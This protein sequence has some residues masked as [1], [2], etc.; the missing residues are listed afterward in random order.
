MNP[1]SKTVST[2]QQ[3]R[4]CRCVHFTGIQHATCSV[5]VKY[6]SFTRDKS[7]PCLLKAPLHTEQHVCDKY[8][9]PTPEQMEAEDRAHEKMFADVTK[10]RAAIMV[11]AQNKRGVAGKLP[12]PVCTTGELRY[13]ISGYNGHVHAGCTT[14]A[15]VGWME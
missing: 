15:C 5:G 14:K 8:L 2:N 3:R 7:L 9:A 12:C 13:S 11:H 1:E 6:E 10:A 4:A